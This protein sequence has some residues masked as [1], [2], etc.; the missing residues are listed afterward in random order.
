MLGLGLS[1]TRLFPPLSAGI[2][3]GTLLLED[4][5]E[6]LLE[7]GGAV[8]TEFELLLLESGATLLLEDGNL[9]NTER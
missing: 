3:I 5:S 2:S 4:G 7:A 9:F 1:L 8:T 6:L